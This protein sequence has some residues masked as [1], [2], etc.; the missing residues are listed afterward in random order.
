MGA[1]GSVCGK[2]QDV[3]ADTKAQIQALQDKRD[4]AKAI[5]I[6]QKLAKMGASFDSKIDEGVAKHRDYLRALQAALNTVIIEYQRELDSDSTASVL[7]TPHLSV[8]AKSDFFCGNAD[9]SA[10]LHLSAARMHMIA[11]A[12]GDFLSGPAADAVEQLKEA[13]E[14]IKT[15]LAAIDAY[16]TAETESHAAAKVALEALQK[17][18]A[19]SEETRKEEDE[20]KQAKLEKEEEKLEKEQDAVQE[21]ADDAAATVKETKAEALKEGKSAVA[22]A[23]KLVEAAFKLR[24][25]GFDALAKAVVAAA[26]APATSSKVREYEAEDKTTSLSASL[27]DTVARGSAV[28]ATALKGDLPKEVAQKVTEARRLL[29]LSSQAVDKWAKEDGSKGMLAFHGPK[30]EGEMLAALANALSEESAAG[31][32]AA[33]ASGAVGGLGARQAKMRAAADAFIAAV[34]R[35][36]EGLEA[37]SGARQDYESAAAAEKAQRAAID[38]V[39]ALAAAKEGAAKLMA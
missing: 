32:K 19:K 36:H 22:A 34:A 38:R 26:A 1:C 30:A 11:A 7:T 2:G 33:V 17:L 18:K 23:A 29:T 25:K 9:T 3:V 31:A 20:A 8:W 13:K 15:A 5:A 21:K 6:D 16:L 27:T 4:E 39:A 14:T 12:H 24:E 10:A 28:A 37:V 35:F